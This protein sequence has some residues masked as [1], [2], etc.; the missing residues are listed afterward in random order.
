[1]HA[2]LNTQQTDDYGWRILFFVGAGI[3]LVA[4]VMRRHMA[5]T[6]SFAAAREAGEVSGLPIKRVARDHRRGIAQVF[7]LT[8]Y[9]GIV[10]WLA[11]TYVPSY[12]QD[13]IG[14]TPEVAT[15]GATLAAI[16]Y[17]VA[18]PFAGLLSDHVGRRPVM[19][20]G[21]VLTLLFA[22]PVFALLDDATAPATIAGQLILMV[23]VLVYT[24]PWSSAVTE[25]FPTATRYTGMA[26]GFNVSVAIFGGTAPLVATLLIKITGDNQAP[27]FYLIGA[28][29]LILLVLARLPET[30]RADIG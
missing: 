17:A 9:M 6:P 15:L 22:Y 28:S 16:L 23:F 30:Y 19:A 25:L 11:A 5:E 21:A 3:G 26:I 8:A 4:L 14:T 20:A 29:L 24:G 1:M 10:Y 18:I 2:V 12:L 7:A 13:P 27:A